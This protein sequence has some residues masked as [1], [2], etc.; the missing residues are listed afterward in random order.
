[1]TDNEDEMDFDD[2][3]DEYFAQHIADSKYK[4]ADLRKIA[5]D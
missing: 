2:R 4:L 3:L 5:D 1:M